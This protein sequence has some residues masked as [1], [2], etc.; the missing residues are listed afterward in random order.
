MYLRLQSLT[1]VVETVQKI[2]I[3]LREKLPPP[4]NVVSI[5]VNIVIDSQKR[6]QIEKIE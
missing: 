1:N 6:L 4:R 5:W 2:S 3:Q